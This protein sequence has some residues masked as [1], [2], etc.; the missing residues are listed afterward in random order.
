MRK[1]TFGL[2]LICS[3]MFISGCE[4]VKT[5]SLGMGEAMVK[6][7]VTTYGVLQQIDLWL[8]KN[9]W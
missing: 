6:D 4:T 2:F 5:A 3:L 9:Y 7:T 8:Q 1:V